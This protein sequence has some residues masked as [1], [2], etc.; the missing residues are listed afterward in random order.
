MGAIEGVQTKLQY[1]G[2]RFC[3]TLRGSGIAYSP[4]GY[5]LSRKFDLWEQCCL[6]RTVKRMEELADMTNRIDDFR[7][8]STT[9]IASSL[10]SGNPA[11][12]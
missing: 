12:V 1:I 8:C 2:S 6:M 5:R 7:H 9:G 10:K 3:N 4:C 11:E